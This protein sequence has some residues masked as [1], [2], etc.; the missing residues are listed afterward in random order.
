MCATQHSPCQQ[1]DSDK[2]ATGIP[3]RQL[4]RVSDW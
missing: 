1:C 3:Y 4:K 2:I